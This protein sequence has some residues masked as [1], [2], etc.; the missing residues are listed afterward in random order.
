MSLS[1]AQHCARIL[2]TKMRVAEHSGAAMIEPH[3]KVF[4]FFWYRAEINF[5]RS[6]QGCLLNVSH[7][8]IFSVIQEQSQLTAHHLSPVPGTVPPGKAAVG[9]CC[10]VAP[11]ASWKAMSGGE[12]V[13][14]VD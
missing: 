8:S 2:Q 6:D 10:K 9:Q 4:F 14:E 12:A 5:C 1:S 3:G 7:G 13:Q 11:V